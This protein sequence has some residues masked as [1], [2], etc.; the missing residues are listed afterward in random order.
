MGLLTKITVKVDDGRPV[1]RLGDFGL[2]RRLA[3]VAIMLNL[4]ACSATSSDL[5]AIFQSLEA[6]AYAIW[7]LLISFCYFAGALFVARGIFD[8]KVYG[9]QRTASAQQNSLRTPLTYVTVGLFL[10]YAPNTITLLSVSWLMQPTV[11]LA[12]LNPENASA[13]SSTWASLSVAMFTLLQICG[14]ISFIR[15]CFM[16]THIGGGQHGGTA[17]GM[18]HIVSGIIMLNLQAFLQILDNSI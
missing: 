3:L 11:M 14:L 12:Y 13:G 2:N 18:T 16:L 6:D 15:G 9:E 4:S 7:N 10:L 8:F 17:K 1:S 5:S